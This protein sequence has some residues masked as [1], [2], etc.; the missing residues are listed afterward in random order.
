MAFEA[1]PPVLRPLLRAYLLGYASSVAPRL[2]TLAL[3]S[4]SKRKGNRAKDG[5]P[6]PSFVESVRGVLARGF[7]LQRFPTFCAALVGGSTL[8]EASNPVTYSPSLPRIC[9]WG[10]SP[11]GPLP[12]P[13]RRLRGP[14]APLL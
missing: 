5:Q 11:F 7:D 3:Q 1:I 8:L 4:F 10:R 2:L 14:T 9:S 12:K 13:A 6:Q